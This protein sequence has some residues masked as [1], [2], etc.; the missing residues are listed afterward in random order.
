MIPLT[1]QQEDLAKLLAYI[2][3]HRPD[4]FGLVLDEEGFAGVKQL[5]AALAGEA[6]WGWVRR[7]HLEE[8]AVL[9]KPPRLELREDRLRSLVPAP[10][11][12]RRPGEP[13]PPLLYTAIPPKAQEPVFASG[14]QAAAGREILLAATPERALKLGRRRS[15]EP[16]LVTVQA[17]AA[18][19]KGLA[20]QGY[21][22]G[23]FLTGAIP[24]E[25]LQVPPPP[26]KREKPKAEKPAPPPPLPGSVLLDLPQFLGKP[27][28]ARG[29]GKKG[30][31]AWKSGTRALR[32]ERR[33]TPK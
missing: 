2:L 25:F 20:F 33:K 21:G 27:A 4:E 18:A 23:L 8:L 12:L 24:R 29:K 14:L 22:E 13:P 26:Q 19:R 17:Q 7:R 32:R 5:L 31:P 11:R 10:A 28:D 9:L 16:I 30:E 6:G 3:G 1:R 15:P